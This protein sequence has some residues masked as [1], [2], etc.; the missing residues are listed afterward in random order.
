MSASTRPSRFSQRVIRQVRMDS[1]RALVRARYCPDRSEV[2]QMRC[3]DNRDESDASFGRQLWFFE[4]FGV[5]ED[6]TKKQVFGSIEYSLQFGLHE[7]VDDGV[8]D[9][10]YQRRDI[11]RVYAGHHAGPAWQHPM[12]RFLIVSMAAVALAY[13]TYLSVRIAPW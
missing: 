10:E 13:L 5:D 6:D 2:I 7:L 12:H 9:S 4:G 11:S 8:F 1:S 3:I